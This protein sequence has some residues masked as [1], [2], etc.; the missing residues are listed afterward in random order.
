MLCRRRRRRRRL[1]RS[2]F[3]YSFNVHLLYECRWTN[4]SS[5][6]HRLVYWDPFAASFI[7]KTFARPGCKL[8]SIF[9]IIAP[10][11]HSHWSP[12]FPLIPHSTIKMNKKFFLFF[13]AAKWRSTWSHVER[14]PINQRSAI[15]FS[16]FFLSFGLKPKRRETCGGEWTL[17]NCTHT[18]TTD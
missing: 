6:F 5:H 1:Q 16:C 4:P 11:G 15:F 14:L 10:T 3:L 12:Y 18:R 9:F 2:E 8:L 7:S 17:G 13:F